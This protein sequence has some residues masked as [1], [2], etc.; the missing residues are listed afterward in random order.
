MWLKTLLVVRGLSGPE[1]ELALVRK[2]KP[3][4]FIGILLDYKV[5]EKQKLEE[6]RREEGMGKGSRFFLG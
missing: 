6:E 5:E 4:L 3:L 2:A 1:D